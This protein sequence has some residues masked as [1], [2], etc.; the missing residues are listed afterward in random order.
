[1]VNK[2]HGWML[3]IWIEV[4]FWWEKTTNGSEMKVQENHVRRRKSFRWL[5]IYYGSHSFIL[6]V[7][8]RSARISRRRS[9]KLND[10]LITSKHLN[11]TKMQSLVP[12]PSLSSA[13]VDRGEREGDAASGADS[14]C[15]LL[16]RRPLR[17]RRRR[18]GN[19]LPVV[20]IPR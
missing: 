5:L 19:R 20:H 7:G 1:M 17:H 11:H 3:R 14:G 13:T 10:V 2:A 4:F 8:L 6:L 18:A 12:S 15:L 16:L 9:H